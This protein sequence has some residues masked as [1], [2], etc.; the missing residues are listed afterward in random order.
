MI[1]EMNHDIYIM[2][3]HLKKKKLDKIINQTITVSI[4][5]FHKM[6]GTMFVK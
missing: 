2:V 3:I 5:H 6:C 4:L 1:D